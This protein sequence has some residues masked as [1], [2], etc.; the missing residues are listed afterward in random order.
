MI[1]SELI[2]QL[3]QLDG[4]LPVRVWAD[5]GQVNMQAGEATERYC[6][7]SDAGEY[8]LESCYNKPH[9]KSGDAPFTLAECV[10]FCEIS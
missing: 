9:L 1:V 8:M 5:H 3:Q 7:A 10:P 4:N 2:A 6:A